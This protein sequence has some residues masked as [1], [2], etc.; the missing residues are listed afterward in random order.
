[1]LRRAWC[2]GLPELIDARIA[3]DSIV[4]QEVDWLPDD[5]TSPQPQNE[6]REEVGF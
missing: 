5:E 1:M 3:F 4:G 6:S 2:Y